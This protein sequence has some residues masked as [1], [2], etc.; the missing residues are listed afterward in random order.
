VA[1]RIAARVTGTDQ[2]ACPDSGDVAVAEAATGTLTAP[3]TTDRLADVPDLPQ[4]AL[5]TAPRR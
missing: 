4:R 3:V 2:L 1:A 5:L